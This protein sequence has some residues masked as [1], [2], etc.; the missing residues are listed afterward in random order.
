MGIIWNIAIVS[1]AM[2]T[3]ANPCFSTPSGLSLTKMHSGPGALLATVFGM[4]VWLSTR[5]AAQ[6][7]RLPCRVQGRGTS[8]LGPAVPRCIRA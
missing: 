6:I 3:F 4:I 1:W 5:D 8:C 7:V 2:A